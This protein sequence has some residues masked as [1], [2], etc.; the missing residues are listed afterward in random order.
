MLLCLVCKTW[1]QTYREH[2]KL[3][4]SVI[5]EY[6]VNKIVTVLINNRMQVFLRIFVICGGS[7]LR[8]VEKD[9]CKPFAIFQ[10]V[11][12]VGLDFPFSI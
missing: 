3:L 6:R 10:R 5:R 8:K 9:T 12:T 4:F 1:L 11:V 7:S 2:L